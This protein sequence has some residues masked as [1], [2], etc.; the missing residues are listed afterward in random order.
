MAVDIIARGLAAS[1]VG[2]DGKISSDKMPIIKDILDTTGFTPVGNL[3][4][5]TAILGKTAE[6]ILIMILFGIVNP[7]FTMPSASIQL[8]NSNLNHLTVGQETLIEGIIK[9][10]RGSITPSYSPTSK[11]RGGPATAYSINGE[12][13]TSEA[14]SI[15]IMPVLGNNEIA[16]SVS[17][18]EGDQPINSL[19]DP[20]DAPL[21]PGAIQDIFTLVGVYP[22]LDANGEEKVF[23][24]FEDTDGSG[25]MSI[26][27]SE[28][29]GI[30]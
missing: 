12:A 18:A 23:N 27:A 13:L 16:F 10:D 1:L 2:S 11:Y 7:T 17:Y 25:Y 19:G 30:K 6:E 20:F 28:S 22:L 14:F 3:T 29:S 21:S 15:K 4:D 9:Y 8:T 5:P 26:F 24:W